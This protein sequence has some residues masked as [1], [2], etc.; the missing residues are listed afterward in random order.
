[1]TSDTGDDNGEEED[2]EID[3]SLTEL[4]NNP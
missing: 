2:S 3:D 1:L 4:I